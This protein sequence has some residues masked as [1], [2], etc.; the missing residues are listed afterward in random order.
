[1]MTSSLVG[2]ANYCDQRVC[3]FVCLFF[4]PL[5]ISQKQHVQIT[6]NFPYMLPVAAAG[7]FSGGNAISYVLPVLCMKSCFHIMVE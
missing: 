4:C 7:S 3:L 6:L 2:G 5:R 1:M